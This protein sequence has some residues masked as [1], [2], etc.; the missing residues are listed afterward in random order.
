MNIQLVEKMGRAPCLRFAVDA[1]CWLDD[2]GWTDGAVPILWDDKA[3]YCTAPNGTVIGV[4]TFAHIEWVDEIFIKIGFVDEA[5]RQ[6]GIYKAMFA[7]LV[8]YAQEKKAKVI[9]GGRHVKN[10]RK[11]AADE[12]MHRQPQFVWTKFPVPQ[13]AL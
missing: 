9:T 10:L 7:R 2:Q 3:V 12:H 13:V 5:H 1:W 6:T 8:E 11:Q 4:I